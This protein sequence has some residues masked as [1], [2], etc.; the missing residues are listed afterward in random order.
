M[1]VHAVV[2]IS[3]S[4]EIGAVPQHTNI[5]VLP[6]ILQRCRGGC[7][8]GGVTNHIKASIFTYSNIKVICLLKDLKFKHSKCTGENTA[9][10]PVMSYMTQHTYKR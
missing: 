3:C 1:A 4:T 10:I 6:R 9:N 2:S 5:R 7:D 8:L